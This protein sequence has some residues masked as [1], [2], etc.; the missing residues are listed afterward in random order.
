MLRRAPALSE[1]VPHQDDRRSPHRSAEDAVE[2]ERAPVHTA[3]ASN[4]RLKYAENRE[5]TGHEDGP[6]AMEREEPFEVVQPLR[7]ELHIS[8]PLQN[9]RSSRS[10]TYQITDL[11]SDNSPNDANHDGVPD[12]KVALLNEYASARSTA[13][14]GKGMPAVPSITP[15]RT[16]TYP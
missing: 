14:L 8:P 9:E 11:I 5:E 2:E 16:I 12:V 7:G 13:A 4:Q 15:K 1:E 6:A 10:V 3:Y